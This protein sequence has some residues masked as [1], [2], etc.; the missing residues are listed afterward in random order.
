VS[1]AWELGMIARAA[2]VA[3]RDNPFSPDE[4]P[5]RWRAWERGWLREDR[6]IRNGE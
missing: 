5:A 6:K 2:G 4:Q 3:L 1:R